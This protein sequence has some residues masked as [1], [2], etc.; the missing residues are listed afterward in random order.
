MKAI[1]IDLKKRCT[2]YDKSWT[3][4][5]PTLHQIGRVVY[6]RSESRVVSRIV[7]IS[8]VSAKR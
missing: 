7:C 3:V 6:D 4:S 5:P 8:Y 2:K 1:A